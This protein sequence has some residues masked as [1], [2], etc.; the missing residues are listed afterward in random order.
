MTTDVGPIGYQIVATYRCNSSCKWCCER[1]D[2][3]SW[4]HANT[5]VT[6]KEIRSAAYALRKCGISVGRLRITGGEPLL[7]RKLRRLIRTVN[8]YW[9]PYYGFTRVYTNGTLRTLSPRGLGVRFSTVSVTS[10]KKMEGFFPFNV[11]PMDLGLEAKWGVA[12]PCKQQTRCGRSFSCF[13]FSFCAMA[14]VIGGLI[15]KDC[16]KAR[17]VLRGDPDICQHC[18]VSLHRSEV[19]KIYQSVKAGEI[20]DTTKTY[21]EGFRRWRDKPFRPKRYFERVAEEEENDGPYRHP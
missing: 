11:S 4:D 19:N 5:D 2:R 21:R 16:Y 9:K 7:Y 10:R 20:E 18:V 17:P 8:D 1:L 14:G 12:A 15:G 13:G 3:I 6:L